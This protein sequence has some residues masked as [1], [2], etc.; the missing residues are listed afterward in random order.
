MVATLPGS[1]RS[2]ASV[3]TSTPRSR[4]RAA[5]SCQRA[6]LAG[7]EHQVEAP[8]RRAV[9][10]TRRPPPRI[11]R[12]SPP[13]VRTSPS[14]VTVPWS[15]LRA[16][17][18]GSRPAHRYNDA[19]RRHPWPIL[20]ACRESASRGHPRCPSTDD[21]QA[22][23]TAILTAATRLGRSGRSTGSR[24]RRSPRRPVSRYA[25]CTA[26]T[27]RSTTCTPRCFSSQVA[28]LSA[29]ARRDTG[30]DP[31]AAVAELMAGACRNMLRTRI[32][33]TR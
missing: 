33:P 22:R 25:R 30:A 13:T 10:R 27:R 14:S 5:V 12:R 23:R 2:I 32:L 18:C 26:T 8:P 6:G 31:A 16:S 1:T 19:A 17:R 15:R 3:R 11:H 4:Q 20:G 21:Q 28:E 29:S 7:E 9:G 24:R